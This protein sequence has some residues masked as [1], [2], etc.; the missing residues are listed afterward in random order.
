[1]KGFKTFA[2]ALLCVLSAWILG[3]NDTAPVSSEEDGLGITITLPGGKERAVFYDI[4][5]VT[6]YK[7]S[8]SQNGYD[9]ASKSAEPGATVK[10]KVN[11][12]GTYDISVSALDSNGNT[13]ANGIASVTLAL[14]D[15]YKNVEIDIEPEEKSVGINLTAAWETPNAEKYGAED[16]VRYDAYIYEGETLVG[17]YEDISLTQSYN[18]PFYS[19]YKI[20]IEAKKADLTVVGAGEASFTIAKGDT[21]K[22]I[23]ITIAGK[24]IESAGEMGINPSLNWVEGYR[25]ETVTMGSWPQSLADVTG[26]TLTATGKT[27][28]GSNAEYS[29]DDGNKYVKVG[30]SYYKVEPLTWRVIAYNSDGSK[31][32]LADK[33]YSYIV[34]YGTDDIRTLGD[35]TIYP[36]NYKYS[37]IRAYLNSTKNQ[38]ETDGGIPTSYDIDWTNTGFLT[39]AFSSTELQKIKTVLVDNSASTTGYNPNQYAC[40]NTVD[41]ITLLSFEEVGKRLYGFHNEA[42]RIMKTTAYARVNSTYQGDGEDYSGSW[43]VRSPWT[44]SVYVHFIP[45]IG[46]GGDC[47]VGDGSMGIVPVLTVME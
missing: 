46:T 38:F 18:V 2:L 39:A 35:K 17:T 22:D 21:Y 42:D 3:C 6:S 28:D 13:I 15:G 23:S 47:G 9:V 45:K 1:M 34:F 40:E 11:D 30:E 24:Y 31:K 33:I 7:I 27:Y 32:L 8:I 20:K 36:N 41:K 12:A 43:W 29:G 25:R 4:E 5:E 37:N 44:V 26:V 16:A 10:I 14:G 19:T